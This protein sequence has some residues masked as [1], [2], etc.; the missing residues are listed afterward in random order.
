[1]D[2]DRWLKAFQVIAPIAI[3]AIFIVLL[4]PSLETMF[5]VLLCSMVV[6][7]FG[8]WV[9]NR[10]QARTIKRLDAFQLEFHNRP[11][12]IQASALVSAPSSEVVEACSAGIEA[13]PNLKGQVDCVPPSKL[14]A[15]TGVGRFSWGERISVR[16][17]ESGGSTRL[18]IS[19]KPRLWLTSNDQGMNFQNVVLILRSVQ[20]WHQMRSIEPS[21]VAHALKK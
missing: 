16:I 7:G 17:E 3:V 13:L 5:Q 15:R 4:R 19:S 10:F 2:G 14:L 12:G 1:M 6:V 11:D 9:G 8:S 18:T 21:E 20:Q